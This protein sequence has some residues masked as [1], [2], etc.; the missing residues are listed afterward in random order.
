MKKKG[1]QLI[2]PLILLLLVIIPFQKHENTLNNPQPG[3]REP[4]KE[5]TPG[6]R[7]SE[8]VEP[9]LSINKNTEH[10]KYN[11]ITILNDSAFGPIGYNFPGTGTANDPYLIEGYNITDSSGTLIHIENTIV[12]FIIQDCILDGISKAHKGIYLHNV[13]QGTIFNNVLRNNYQSCYLYDSDYNNTIENNWISNTADVAIGLS[14]SR[15]NGVF[16]NEI[17]NSHRGIYVAPYSPYSQIFRNTITDVLSDGVYIGSD[18]S[19]SDVINNT[20]S[21][22]GG[23]GV[24]LSWWT[25]NHEI[26]GN[27]ISNTS[28]AGIVLSSTN[29]GGGAIISNNNILNSKHQGILFAGS[30]SG[31][32]ITRNTIV[33][34]AGYGIQFNTSSDNNEVTWNTFLH[35]NGGGTQAYDNG[36]NNVFEYNHWNDHVGPDTDT[37][38]FVDSGYSIVNGNTDLHPRVA[39]IWI[40]D[41]SDFMDFALSGNGTEDNP[42][43]IKG[44]HFISNKSVL[45]AIYNTTAYFVIENCHLDGINEV[46]TGIFLYNVTSGTMS[47]NILSNNVQ[48][49]Y[50]Y[51]SHYNI[52][53]NNWLSNTSSTSIVLTYSGHNGIFDNEIHNSGGHGIDVSPYSGSNQIFRNTIIDIALNGVH[54][55]SD[56]SHGDAINN[57]LSNIEGYGVNVEWNTIHH[58][59]IGNL[60]SNTSLAGIR[61]ASTGAAGGYRHGATISNN[62]ILN[63][64]QQGI[65]LIGE[66][67]D[68]PITRNTIFNCTGYGLEINTNS[69]DNEV[70][71][72]NFF[73]NNGGGT[74]AFDNGTNNVFEYNHWNDYVGPDVDTDGFVDSNY[75]ING[76]LGA[77]K[78]TGS[79]VTYFYLFDPITFASDAITVELWMKWSGW[80]FFAWNSSN[81]ISYYTD[82]QHY[83]FLMG[84]N[85]SA[86]EFM[87]YVADGALSTGCS[88]S[89]NTWTHLVVT[90]RSSDGET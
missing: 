17:Q 66:N 22:I 85:D 48:C 59:I 42:Y 77:L 75:Q 8:R 64:K 54:F 88:L 16:D 10:Q 20:L 79:D 32:P 33:N 25:R 53:E 11:R 84:Y 62:T 80:S 21:N 27:L 6:E 15:N 87:I 41:N 34:C 39:P 24:V 31:V 28:G 4:M 82:G 19:H 50:L 12:C 3:T 9:Q 86:D 89:E 72:N 57:T 68:V 5:R 36:T 40:N 30:N 55:K 2:L 44:H 58:E 71:W 81:L 43:K 1:T 18:S 49:C 70:K 14:N 52:I 67:Y 37:D 61:L 60:I 46:H 78:F 69:D 51:R 45:I 90:W 63:S 73:H 74:Q 26:R 47:H 35:N 83:A 13:T 65:Q 23:N 38:G 29:Y 76:G 7:R 56:S